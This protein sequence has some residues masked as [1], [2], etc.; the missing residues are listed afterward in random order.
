MYFSNKVW[1][2]HGSVA[3]PTE[4]TDGSAKQSALA[5]D[6][7]RTKAGGHGLPSYPRLAA[8]DYPRTLG[9]QPWTTLVPRLAAMDYPR[10]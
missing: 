2:M 4:A 10:T 8:M 3:L 9:W 1:T 5:M 7:R 6:Y